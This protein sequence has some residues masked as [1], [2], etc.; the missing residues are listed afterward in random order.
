M[1]SLGLCH[2]PVFCTLSSLLAVTHLPPDYSWARL[3]TGLLCQFQLYG[4]LSLNAPSDDDL[5][6]LSVKLIKT[7]SLFLC[8]VATC[9]QWL[10][11]G[12][13]SAQCSLLLGMYVDS[14]I[15]NT[16]VYDLNHYRVQPP[17][18]R[19]S[20]PCSHTTWCGSIVQL[21]VDIRATST[22]ANKLLWQA[23]CWQTN[24]KI[25]R[26]CSFLKNKPVLILSFVY[27]GRKTQRGEIASALEFCSAEALL[28]AIFS[29]S[30]W[31][32]QAC[33]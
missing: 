30:W 24:Q 33:L 10:W 22:P 14:L 19:Q 18:Q 29:L 13:S 28:N 26:V 4:V 12:C 27:K 7:I 5:W 16:A 11:L 15:T 6:L 17:L 31:E 20:C 1:F 2:P 21:D 23:Q 3:H 9:S 8:S 32:L 25:S